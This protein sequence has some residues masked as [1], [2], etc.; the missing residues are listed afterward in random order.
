MSQEN[1]QN[2]SKSARCSDALSH[3]AFQCLVNLVR[4]LRG[5]LQEPSVQRTLRKAP[6][7][8]SGPASCL[9]F[10]ARLVRGVPITT[11]N[12]SGTT[13]A[14]S[15]IPTAGENLR[16]RIQRLK[17]ACV[18][19]RLTSTP[20]RARNPISQNAT[21]TRTWQ[22]QEVIAVWACSCTVCLPATWVSRRNPRLVGSLKQH[23]HAILHNVASSRT[24]AQP[25]AANSRL[26]VTA[27][28]CRWQELTA[29]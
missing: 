18:S 1:E 15:H 23:S 3:S 21:C 11:K 13:P 7:F 24:R 9:A 12:H 2:T 25:C 6:L 19:M 14:R 27:D 8:S 17:K 28:D 5:E 16:R 10:T 29:T 26:Q 22:D 4:V 20:S